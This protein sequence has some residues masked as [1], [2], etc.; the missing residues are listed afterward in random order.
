MLIYFKSFILNVRKLKPGEKEAMCLMS[1]SGLTQ[2]GVRVQFCL[3]GLCSLTA[4]PFNER[5]LDQ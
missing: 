5:T 3:L 2:I 1:D 4:F